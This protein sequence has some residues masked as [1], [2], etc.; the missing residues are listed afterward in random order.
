MWHRTSESSD[1][2]VEVHVGHCSDGREHIRS[3]IAQCQD[4]D[5]LP[6]FRAKAMCI[7]QIK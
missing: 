6:S 2:N 5:S 7:D 1:R 4:R 3:S